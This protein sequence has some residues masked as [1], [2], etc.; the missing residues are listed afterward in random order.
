VENIEPGMLIYVPPKIK[1]HII[2]DSKEPL[3]IYFIFTPPSPEEQL[4]EK[5]MKNKE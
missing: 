1:H 3:K 4:L 5:I 2:N